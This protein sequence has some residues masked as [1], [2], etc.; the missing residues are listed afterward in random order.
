MATRRSN[1][2]INPEAVGAVQIRASQEALVVKVQVVG[3]VEREAATLRVGRRGLSASG[4]FP[5]ALAHARGIDIGLLVRGRLRVEVQGAV[6]PNGESGG[7]DI[8][9]VAAGILGR[10]TG[11]EGALS[12]LK[13]LEVDWRSGVQGDEA[14]GVAAGDGLSL[15]ARGCGRDGAGKGKNGGDVELHFDCLWLWLML[16]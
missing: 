1:A 16:T 15:A 5:D 6:I 9:G 2:N 8:V 13:G 4:I 3:R 10:E 11:K 14:K 12:G 7:V